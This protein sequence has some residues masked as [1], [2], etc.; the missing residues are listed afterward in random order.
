MWENFVKTHSYEECNSLTLETDY[1]HRK[2]EMYRY[3]SSFSSPLIQIDGGTKW[4]P[5]DLIF[6]GS[7]SLRTVIASMK[8]KGVCF[9]E[10][11]LWQKSWTIKKSDCQ[12]IDAFELWC[13]RVPC[14]ARRSN[15]LILK[16][17]NLSI[18]W[19]VWCRSWSTNTLAT[20]CKELTH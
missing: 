10:E 15:Q 5:A 20:W 3:H 1:I 2:S 4:K 13:L 7:T 17:I 8:S 12:R 16:E 9:W 19:K 6:L 18:F 11:K 14:T